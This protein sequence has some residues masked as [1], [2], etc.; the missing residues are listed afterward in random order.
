MTPELQPF[1]KWSGNKQLVANAI[2]CRFPVRFSGY[3]E[4]FVG[5]GGVF[6]S[7]QKQSDRQETIGDSNSW[8]TDTY[9]ALRDSYTQVIKILESLTP[10]REVYYRVREIHPDNLA[11]EYKAAHLIYL[12]HLCF[13]DMFRV[14]LHGYFN[15]PFDRSGLS[16]VY[17]SDHLYQVHE[18]LQGVQVHTGDF[19][20]LASQ[21]QAGDFIYLDPPGKG[22]SFFGSNGSS[23]DSIRFYGF[24]DHDYHRLSRMCSDLDSRGV[25]WAISDANTPLMRILFSK[26]HRTTITVDS[27]DQEIKSL[28]FTNYVTPDEHRTKELKFTEA[29]S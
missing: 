11:P 21:V 27:S 23:F 15:V 17:N 28:L 5:G 18:R 14:N 7:L 29:I 12:N 24:K 9:R 19:V 20:D 10:C 4:P 3:Y 16:A 26:Y 25:F 6:L 13:G 1:L 22:D 2:Q 8:L